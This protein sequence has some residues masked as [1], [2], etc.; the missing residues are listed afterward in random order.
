M[1]EK[2]GRVGRAVILAIVFSI[3]AIVFLFPQFR[4]A[5]ISVDGLRI[6]HRE[7]VLAASGLTVGQ[8][9]FNG[10]GPDLVRAFSLRYGGGEDR[11]SAMS[12]YIRSVRIR[13]G[14]PSAISIQIE[15]RVEVA[16][17]AIPDGCVV[18]DAQGVAVEILHGSAPQGIP[19]VQGATVSSAVLGQALKVDNELS[20][21]S[22]IVI[23]DAII[24]SDR[25]DG[26][27]SL[28]KSIEAL[29][30]VDVDATYMTVVLPA[31]GER[32]VVRIGAL[33]SIAETVEWLRSAIANGHCDG[34][35]KGVLDLSG[36]QKVFRPDAR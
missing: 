25:E 9:L 33:D 20:V 23:M 13:L 5:S 29:R 4:C 12:P 16:Y 30:S 21:R 28:F 15:E 18:I 32:L 31:A 34:L 36:T 17:L 26:R 7:D 24:K 19:V 27:F 1:A 14:F 35:G 10:L 8:H 11:I 22:A 3:A 6:L 2:S